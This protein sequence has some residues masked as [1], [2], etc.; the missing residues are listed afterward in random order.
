MQTDAADLSTKFQSLKQN[1][2]FERL[3]WLPL[4]ITWASIENE[5]QMLSRL[6]MTKLKAILVIDVIIV[7]IATGTYFF[8]QTQGLLAVAPK[9]A[10]F[11]VTNLT[12]DPQVADVGQP[13]TIS[14]NMTNVGEIDGSYAANLTINDVLKDNQTILVAAGASSIVEFTDTENAEGNYTAK[15]GDLSGSF[16]V[17]A[18]PP[19]ISSIS[20]SN[21]LANPY[22]V[23][24]GDSVNI[25][26]TAKNQGIEADSLS[27]KLW[28]DGAFA[29]AQ[30]VLLDAE[31][32]TTVAFAVNT[33]SEGMHKI[34]VN[35]LFGSFTVVP[36]GM[37]TLK[38]LTSPV[39]A[40]VVPK[41]KINGQEHTVPYNEI[42]NEGD[43][44]IEMPAGDPTGTNSFLHW[45]N[46]GT[47]PTRTIHL[48]KAMLLVAYYEQGTG[49]CP[50]LFVWNGTDYVYVAEVSNHG[51]L[52]YTRYVNEDGSLEYWRNNP[53]DYILLNKNQLQPINGYYQ[54]NL[55]Q[56]WDEIFF[57]DS[58][59]MLV[60]DH[61]PNQNVYSTM[62]E[63]YID[64][65]Y[66][67]QIYTVSKNPLKPVS[68]FNE[69]V[70]VCNGK[71]Y[72]SN[73]KADVLS[74]ISKTDGVFTTAFNGKYSQAWNN[75]TWNRLTLNLG[76][77]ADA[78]QI[79]LVV[80]ALVDW[81]PAESYNVWMNKFYSA[82]V[83]NHTEPTPAPFM[84]VKDANGNWVRVPDSRQFPLPPDGVARTFV[85]NLTGLF[86]S[87]DYSLRI[88][89]FWNVTF[90]YIGVDITPQANVTIQRIDPQ[91][92]LYQAFTSPSVS[93][94][95]FTRYGDVTQLLLSE[96]D[97]FVIGKQGD[98]V[99]LQFPTNNL[100][101]PAEGMERDY[102]FFVACWFKVE[103]A[104]YGFGPGFGFTVDPLPFHNMSG[105]PYPLDAESY[106]FSAH[107]RYLQEYNTRVIK[108]S[109]QPQ[110]FSITTWVVVVITLLAVINL[111]VL[112]HF[113]KRSR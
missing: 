89:N 31:K 24:I 29:D 76:N 15:I 75:Q 60:V 36:K 51:W 2:I 73:N 88:S 103:Y 65:N 43:Y 46:G 35:T 1:K 38:I 4:Y 71:V 10:E 45:E 37:H 44:T 11:T 99:S 26:V 53:W 6:A 19:V 9:Q 109:S 61:S 70:T 55:T 96:D 17:K 56:R 13:V 21:L 50:S 94:G 77:L 91:A 47:N 74:A 66:M 106:P 25:T 113:K 57:V 81:G 79:N 97:E 78:P 49:S 23:N 69:I 98:A 22:E 16:A 62:V 86:P 82:Q 39:P 3:K 80:R 101:A 12:I 110:E 90:D 5:R 102:F 58:A 30:I 87:N 64:P 54:L 32:S 112:V 28:I 27:V 18:V 40:K 67:G 63:Q 59:Y 8:L 48:T 42:L 20:L 107:L 92:I 104:N 84:E 95:N 100:T 108:P 14:A 85:V 105:F 68:A 52:G 93:S 41:V 111:S 72:D 7:A 83:P 33:T 34:K